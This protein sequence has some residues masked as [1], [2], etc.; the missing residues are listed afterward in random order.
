MQ[1]IQLKKR[2][3]GNIR[4]IGELYKFNMLTESILHDCI[5]KLLMAADEESLELMCKLLS[6]TG[7]KLDHD[8]AKVSPSWPSFFCDLKKQNQ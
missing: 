1:V 3:L 5:I 8:K 6:T 4:F 2:S 7:F